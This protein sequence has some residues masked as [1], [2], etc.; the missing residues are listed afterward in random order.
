MGF[1]EN[2]KS[3]LQYQGIPV[4]KLAADSG[5]NI[6]SINNYLNARGQIPSVEIGVKIARA[7]GVSV[8]N[9]VNGEDGK[10]DSP[11]NQS[12]TTRLIAR[13]AEKLDP[14]KRE[15]AFEF[16]KWLLSYKGKT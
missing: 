11:N 2:L 9:L 5:V 14:Q 7:L 10:N 6:H 8:E 4:K 1:R 15:L 13:F 12:R 16:I 3:E